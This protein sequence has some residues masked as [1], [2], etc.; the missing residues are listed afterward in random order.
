MESKIGMIKFVNCL[1]LTEYVRKTEFGKKFKFFSS[2]P[3]ELCRKMKNNDLNISPVSSVFYAMNYSDFL[4]IPDVCIS[5]Q[6]VIQSVILVSKKPIDDLDVEIIALSTMSLTSQCM[7]KIILKKLYHANPLFVI[8]EIDALMPIQGEEVASL[9][10]GDDALFANLNRIK[11]L[12]YYD[13]G[14]L[15]NQLT[16]GGMVYALWLVNKI[17]AQQ[18]KNDFLEISAHIKKGLHVDDSQLREICSKYSL[19]DGLDRS[20]LYCYLTNL[21]W[22]FSNQQLAELLNFYSLALECGFLEKMPE[23]N[24]AEKCS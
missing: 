4:I 23:L 8:R 13:I 18:M 14:Q 19:Y 15:W 17:Y 20:Q 6:S 7:L 1:P 21:N 3:S 5:A 11:S 9:L 24:F 12:Y 10:I 16:G 22:C 2:V